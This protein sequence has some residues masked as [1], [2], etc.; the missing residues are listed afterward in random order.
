MQ[1]TVTVTLAKI[2]PRWVALT[3]IGGFKV[4]GAP[5]AKP[6]PAL[7]DLFWKLSGNGTRDDDAE[8]GVALLV[9]GTDLETE[10]TRQAAPPS[11]QLPT[12]GEAVYPGVQEDVEAT[13]WMREHPD[14]TYQ[15]Y[16]DE[17]LRPGA[18][19]SSS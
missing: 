10:M 14:R 2:G 9:A 5:A 17:Q 7:K 4:R 6:E 8:L 15:D 16:L 13:A 3:E 12:L 11:Q 1:V 19:G 18:G